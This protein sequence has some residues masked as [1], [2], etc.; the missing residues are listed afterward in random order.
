MK[1][2]Y[3]SKNNRVFAGVCGGLGDYLGIDPLIIRVLWL[4]T[5]FFT[6]TAVVLYLVAMLILPEG[7]TVSVSPESESSGNK[8]WGVLLIVVGLV[9][10]LSR[11]DPFLPVLRRMGFLGAGAFWGLVLIALGLYLLVGT[12]SAAGADYFLHERLQNRRWRR[13]MVEGRLAGVCAG[14]GDYLGIDP[15]VI[16]LLWILMAFI[17]LGLAV[18][19]YFLFA[20]F[21]PRSDE[22]EL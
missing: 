10:L 17:S 4:L 6:G 5:T 21:L 14:L 16:R 22:I 1:R 18:L 15:N 20:I 19:A 12:S 13:N 2:L 7:E 11:V 8:F 9:M 3:R